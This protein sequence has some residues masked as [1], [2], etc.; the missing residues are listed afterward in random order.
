VAIPEIRRDSLRFEAQSGD[1]K[2]QHFLYGSI[3]F[4]LPET[5]RGIIERDKMAKI[6]IRY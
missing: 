3:K 6:S 2:F 4:N 1:E 5:S